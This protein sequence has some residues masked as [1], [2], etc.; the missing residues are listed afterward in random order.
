M[1]FRILALMLFA[2]VFLNGGTGTAQS[3]QGSDT[4]GNRIALIDTSALGGSSNSRPSTLNKSLEEFAKRRRLTLLLDSVEIN[5]AI[6]AVADGVDVTKAFMA[7]SARKDSSGAAPAGPHVPNSRIAL[8]QTEGFYHPK[9]GIKG[10]ANLP[11]PGMANRALDDKLRDALARFARLNGLTIMLDVARLPGII[12]ANDSIDVTRAFI[13]FYNGGASTQSAK[14]TIPDTRVAL[15]NTRTFDQKPGIVSLVR[16]MEVV[17][18]EFLPRKKELKEMMVRL[19]KLSGKQRQDL[20]DEFQ[21]KGKKAQA[22][23]QKRLEEAIGPVFNDI[24][25][26]VEQFAR[27]RGINLVLDSSKLSIAMAAGSIDQT[28][29]F[30]SEYNQRHPK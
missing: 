27:D 18:R 3:T 24:G 4:G 5:S 10:L 23:Y 13:A 1:K 29:A 26:S 12:S 17:D 28:T 8:V 16:A 25:K 7:E 19:D 21:K 20:S 2:G 30:I 22:A 15:M 14:L 11:G 6:L 9:S